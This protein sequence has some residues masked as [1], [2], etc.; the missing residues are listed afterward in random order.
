[1]VLNPLL[2]CLSSK[3]N[4]VKDFLVNEKEFSSGLGVGVGVGVGVEA[5]AGVTFLVGLVGNSL[6]EIS[7]KENTLILS[8]YAIAS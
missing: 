8:N 1:M 2:F 7:L 3:V 5:E 6:I 4:D